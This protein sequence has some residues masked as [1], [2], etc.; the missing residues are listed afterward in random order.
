MDKRFEIGRFW[1]AVLRQDAA[2][3]RAF[4]CPDAY[5]N[6][7]C[8]NERFTVEEYLRANCEYPGDWAG[9][10][11]RAE[12]CGDD[13]LVTVVHV[14]PVDRSASFH[15]TSFL[16]LRDGLI[17]AMDEYWADDGPAPAW[18]Q[19]MGIGRKIHKCEEVWLKQAAPEDCDMI[20]KAQAKAFARLLERY[21]DIQTNPASETSQVIFR[22]MR[23]PG[24]RYYFIMAGSETVGM[25]RVIESDD[26][27]RCRISPMGILPAYQG[28]GCAQKALLAA[29]A[30]YPDARL[31]A[32][33]TIKEEPALRCLYEKMGYRPTGREA[34]LQPG[35]TIVYY[36]KRL[37]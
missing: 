37:R 23:Q 36:E 32:L 24:S 6:W 14:H 20:H 19:E 10:V 12:R 15:V 27:E 11:E 7:H 2:A 13:L 26:R 5:V 8:T 29:E 34:E 30:L 18:R 1:E 4:F 17:A 21:R 31:W 9:E 25:L 3:L 22:K 16:R 28:R 33:E 35:M